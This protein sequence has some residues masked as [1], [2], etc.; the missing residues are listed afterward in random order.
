ML[1]TDNL[2]SGIE[3]RQHARIAAKWRIKISCDGKEYTSGVT[4]NV[5]ASGAGIVTNKPI[6][7]GAKAHVLFT[8]FLKGEEVRFD[9][10]VIVR[11]V[12]LSGDAFRCGC[13]FLKL[14]QKWRDMIDSIATESQRAKEVMRVA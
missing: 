1:T 3:R 11:N 10:I 2:S 5:S 8:A 4:E 9:A 12:A 6:K 13:Q 14:N 7:N